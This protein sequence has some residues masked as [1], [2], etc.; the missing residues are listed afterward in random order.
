MDTEDAFLFKKISSAFTESI[1]SFNKN[2]IKDRSLDYNNHGYL[3][4]KYRIENFLLN[5]KLFTLFEK[6]TSVI[7]LIY[8]DRIMRE[9]KAN[10][11]DVEFAYMLY[12]TCLLLAM[13]YHQ[14]YYNSS[15]LIEFSGIKSSDLFLL[16][17]KSVKLIDYHLYISNKEVDKYFMNLLLLRTL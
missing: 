8:L 9:F 3:Y 12:V 16:E 13:K 2:Y 1:F 5:M 7:A 15:A 17:C 11:I 14:D 10:Y 4:L 6:M